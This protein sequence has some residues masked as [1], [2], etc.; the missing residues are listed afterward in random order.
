[1]EQDTFRTFTH[2]IKG[3]LVDAQTDITNPAFSVIVAAKADLEQV[4]APQP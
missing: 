1:M 3:G 4:Y 2:T